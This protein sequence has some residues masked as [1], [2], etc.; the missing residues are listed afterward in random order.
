MIVKPIDSM[1]ERSADA[2]CLSCKAIF[3]REQMAKGIVIA[4]FRKGMRKKCGKVVEMYRVCFLYGEK[5]VTMSWKVIN[6]ILGLAAVDQQFWR[7]LQK[8]L[9]AACESRGFELTVEEKVVLSRIHAETLTDF[10][11]QLLTEF[12]DTP[13]HK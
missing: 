5:G 1:V 7:E 12:A 9:L 4:V 2:R 10:S 6:H 8:D 13:P 3:P 11:K